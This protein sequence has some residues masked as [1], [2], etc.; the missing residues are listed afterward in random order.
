MITRSTT[1]HALLVSLVLLA[2]TWSA[3]AQ[4]DPQFTQYWAVPAYYNAAAAGNHDAIHIA[5]GSRLQ[6]VGIK[7]APMTFVA[8]AD[9]PFRFLEKRWGVGVVLQHESMGLYRS[10]QAGAQLAWK[11]RMLRGMFSA[12][13]QVGLLSETFKGSDFFIPDGDDAHDSS[14]DAIPKNDVSG[15]AFD[16]NAGV[17]FTHKWFWAGLSVTHITSPSVTLKAEGDEEKYYE[18]DAGR[19]FYFMGGSNIPIKNTLFEIQ[20]SFMLKTDLKFFVAEATARVRYNR[21]LSAG[22]GYRLNDAVS[23]MI[24]AEFKNVFLGYAFDYPT[25][26]INK[27]STGSHEVFVTYKVKLDMNEKNKNKQK[28]I[29]LM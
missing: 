18:F 7:H 19:T 28:S 26:A 6:W 2:T 10:M 29:R 23:V 21:F 12:G 14:D 17:M 16:I 25:S 22:V 4:V 27:A 11:K 1:Y 20:P 5:A 24:G 9:M 13:V 3:H 15:N 8:M